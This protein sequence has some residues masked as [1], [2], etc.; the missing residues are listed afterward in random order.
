MGDS[1]ETENGVGQTTRRLLTVLAADVA[2]YSRLMSE[3]EVGTLNHLE[4]LR[5]ILDRE[6]ER[7]RG[8]IANT[9]GDSVI[10]AF[11]SS[12]DAVDAAIGIQ[13]K[14][15]EYN[16]NVAANKRLRFRIG[17]NIGEVS[18]RSDGDILGNGVNIAARLEGIAVPGG[19]CLS[20]NVVEQVD[21]RI[22][23][24]FTKIG[25]HL[26]KN[27]NKPVRVYSTSPSFEHKLARSTQVVRKI[28]ESPLS[29]AASILIVSATVFY[30]V[31]GDFWRA[32]ERGF[33]GDLDLIIQ[34]DLE[35]AEILTQFDLVTEGD[36]GNSK[37]YI[38]RTWGG[39]LKQIN[40]LASKLGGHFASINSDE[41]NQYL[42]ELSRSVEGHWIKIET[43]VQ[44]PMIGFVQKPGSKEPDEGWHWV[45][46][47]PVEY[48]NWKHG[49]PDNYLGNQSL[50]IYW[51]N[52]RKQPTPEW[53]DIKSIRQS[54]IIEIPK[55]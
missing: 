3:D 49:S 50:T 42:F 45:N 16:L 8:R 5:S 46:G 17:I 55:N 21:G 34:S 31:V 52:S 33:K 37:Y 32:K 51:N 18:E 53:E 4:N 19:I 44:G 9:A 13:Q 41:E 54:S 38:I 6:I 30:V 22:S 12:I 20:E 26:V 2:E 48:T 23:V 47:D 36:F 35:P 11:E 15:T 39:T 1:I 25:E 10:A 28:S 24:E 43:D 40:A 14:H 27:I 7:H 29:V